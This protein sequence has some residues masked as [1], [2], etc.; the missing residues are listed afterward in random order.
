MSIKQ[1][2]IEVRDLLKSIEKIKTVRFWN[3]QI[4]KDDAENAYNYPA[5][6]IE[7]SSVDW[8]SEKYKT[9][10]GDT[11][12]ILHVCTEEYN[13]ENVDEL[14]VMV[15]TLDLVTEIKSVIQ[16]YTSDTVAEPLNRTNSEQDTDHDNIIVWRE[17]YR[18]TIND[19]DGNTEEDKV[20]IPSGTIQAVITTDLDIDNTNIRTGDGEP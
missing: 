12:I 9:Q 19:I 8:V 4:D 13:T 7:F 2:F 6:F 3:N 14:D 10:K 1:T 11:V 18:A 15:Q 5:V 17:S 16:N 20:I